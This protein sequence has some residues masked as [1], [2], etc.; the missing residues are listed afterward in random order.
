MASTF[1][2][3]PET[4]G[5]SNGYPINLPFPKGSVAPAVNIARQP[6]KYLGHVPSQSV[7]TQLPSMASLG[8]FNQPSS[9]Y[10]PLPAPLQQH[11]QPP[12][13][14]PPGVMYTSNNN[15]NVIPPPAQMIQDGNQQ[16]DQVNGGVSENLDYD[17]SIM[18]KFIMENAFVAF[19]ANYSIDDQTTDLFF[20]GISSVL[21]ATR[22]PSATIFLAIDYLFK[23][24]N[25][26]SNGIHSIGG[27]SI[28]IIYQN[29]MIAFILANKFNDDKTFTNSSWSQATGILI[30]IINDFERQ[31]LKIFNWELYDNGFLYYEFVKSFQIFKQNQF[32][33]IT[34]APTLLSPIIN[35]G[36]TRNGNFTLKP[37]STN[38]PLSPVSNYE[39]PMLMSNNMF[40]SPSYQGNPRSDFSGANSYYNYYNYNQ[41]RQNYYQ[42]FPNIYSSPIS[43]TQFDYD[44]YN[45]S[46]QQLQQQQQQQQHSF[47]PTAPQLPP[48]RVHQSYNHHLGWKSM[49]DS[50]N[51][52]RFERNYFPYSAVY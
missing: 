47:L 29:T 6:P 17:I 40:S 28:N 44:F 42:Q 33:P 51:H 38:N 37:T 43:E 50:V 5:N 20:K 49:D 2:Y 41:P 52:S 39:T 18:S 14:P 34:T 21:N 48:P 23:Y 9:N 46:N 8:Y 45:F 12:I 36:D 31:W 25:K 4:L 10:Y 24:I 35:V 3:Y 11:Q 13:L 19:N 15:N 26:L 27:N 1:K 30:G 32:K 16:S 7:H 22:L